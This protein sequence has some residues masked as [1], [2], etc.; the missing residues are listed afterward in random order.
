MRF[1]SQRISGFTLI[2][3]LVVIAIIAILAGMLLP[4]LSRAK[5]KAQAIGCNNNLRQLSMGWFLYAD[6]YGDRLIVNHARVETTESRDSWVNNIQDWGQTPDNTNV[7]LIRS[8][9]LSSYV[10]DTV[11]VYKCPGD[12]TVAACGP[13]IRSVSLNSL[14]GDPGKALDQFNPGF[15]Q[16]FKMTEIPEP[17]QTFTFLEEHPDSINDGFFVNSWDEPKWGNVPASYHAGSGN[18]YFADGHGENHRWVVADTVR[19]PKEGALGGGF[20]PIPP[21]DY[22]WLRDRAGIRK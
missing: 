4:A 2:E 9:K 15:R 6:D 5:A 8:G 1:T 13:R 19:P 3:L 22:L 10:G 7:A 16:Y 21:T 14:I 17:S 12:R 11:T 18:V 20:A